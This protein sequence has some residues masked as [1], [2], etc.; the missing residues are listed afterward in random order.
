MYIGQNQI[1][2]LTDRFVLYQDLLC[3]RLNSMSV[4]AM[5][6]HDKT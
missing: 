2:F 3:F 4:R 1:W 6:I 5:D